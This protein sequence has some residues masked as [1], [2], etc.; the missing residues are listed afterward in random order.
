MSIKA[1]IQIF[2]GFVMLSALLLLDVLFTNFLITSAGEADRER[3]TRE[4][5]RTVMSV[6][7]EERML[8]AIAG[9]WAYSD[10]TWNF[11]NGK[12]PEYPKAYLN[13]DVLTEI[14]IS[15]MIYLDKDLG[16]VLFRDFSAPDDASTPQSEFNAIFS[17]EESERIFKNLPEDGFCGIVMKNGDRPIIFS[18]MHIR[19]SDMSGEDAGYLIATMALSPK[20]V[21]RL[22]HGINFSFAIEPVKKSEIKEDMPGIVIEGGRK[23]TYIAGKVL[24]KDFRGGPA[25][26]I[27]GIMPKVDITEADRQLQRLFLY[28]AVAAIAIVLLSGLY[29]SEQLTWRLKRLQQEIAGIRDESRE[30]RRITI[31]R[32]KKDEI[33]SIQRTL[34]DFMAFFSFKEGEKERIDDITIDVYRRFANAGNDLCTKTLEEIAS[35]FTPGDAKFRSAIPRAAKT[36]RGFAKELG[37]LDEELLY[38]YLGSLFSRIGMLS[39]PFSIRTKTSPLTPTERREYD[40]YP[41]KSRDYME[42]V[43]LLRPASGIPYSWNENWDGSGFPQGISATAIPYQARIY[44]VVDAWNEMTRPWPGRRIP[45][46]LEVAERL[47]SMA[48][49]RLDPQL[50]EKF[51]EYLK[52]ESL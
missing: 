18:A 48:G 38:V 26:W 32:K 10:N 7:G 42:S 51:I 40:R 29:L 46:A 24:V 3:L 23:D 41:V 39:L 15:S 28:L 50:V 43:E 21:Q 20:M 12:Y 17:T 27:T 52:K 19:R 25:F 37:V 31:D 1:K 49:T 36:A 16:V 35:S 4:L 6:K 47:R 30:I 5:S 13:R 14:G 44:A 33:A 34:N 11:M 45:D 9:N 8:T 2:L 22:T